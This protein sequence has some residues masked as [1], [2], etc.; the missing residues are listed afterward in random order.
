MRY[1]ELYLDHPK[2]GCGMRRFFVIKEGKHTARL[3][4]PPTST[5]LDVKLDVLAGARDI[6]LPTRR[7]SAHVAADIR[8]N[9]KARKRLHLIVNGT[10]AKAAIEALRDGK[11]GSEPTKEAA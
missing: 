6:E 2:I 8:D 5:S 3:F 1:V 7:H 10:D 11:V 9:Y 4:Y